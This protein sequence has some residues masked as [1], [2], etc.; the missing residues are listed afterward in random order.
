MNLFFKTKWM[1]SL[2][3]QLK[4]KIQHFLTI[5]SCVVNYRTLTIALALMIVPFLPASNLFFRVGF[6]IAERILY[7]SSI[8]FCMLVVLGVR[9]I[10]VTFPK[11]SKVRGES[12]AVFWYQ[13][14]YIYLVNLCLS[15]VSVHRSTNQCLYLRYLWTSL[16]DVCLSKVSLNKFYRFVPCYDV[17]YQNICNIYSSL[18]YWRSRFNRFVPARYQG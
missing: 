7:L 6:V 13:W 2:L 12:N 16:T 18:W 15:M 10:C 3:L 9:H 5:P 11:Y 1:H 14:T 8:G 4:W 17:R